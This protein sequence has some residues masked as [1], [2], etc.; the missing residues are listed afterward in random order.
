MITVH[1]WWKRHDDGCNGSSFGKKNK[2]FGVTALTSLSDDDTNK[3]FQRTASEQVEA[4]LDLAESVGIDG[5]VCSPHELELVKERIIF[6]NYS[7]D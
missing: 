4:M 5:V 6:I 3:I 7:R 2:I 1:F